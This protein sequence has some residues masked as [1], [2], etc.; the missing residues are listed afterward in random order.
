MENNLLWLA[1]PVAIL[2]WLAVARRWKAA[3]FFAKPG[4]ML[5]LLA[6][7]WMVSG[8]RGQLFW[9]ALGLAFSMAG[10]IFLMLP[11]ERF[12]P[13]LVAFL[14]A[15]VA[16]LIGFNPT[17]PPLSLPTVL[18]AILVGLVTIRLFNA[19]ASGLLAAGKESLKM[20]VLIYSI[21]ISLVLISALLTLVRTEWGESPAF[22]V[23][24]G[25]LLF[26]I[27]DLILAWNRF[28]AP[29]T[30]ARLIT[31]VAYHMGQFLLVLGAVSQYR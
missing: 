5:V 23:S 12:I 8:Y 19:I 10:D 21:V 30:R 31:R 28:V 2:D 16:Y 29:I 26:F 20:P 15:H 13:G 25:A 3:G 27:S 4:V 9:F 17:L 22:L 11:K 18:V 1:M 14:L 6:W 24:S 7:L